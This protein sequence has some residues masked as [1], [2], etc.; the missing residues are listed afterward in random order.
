MAEETILRLL[1]ERGGRGILQ[2]EISEST[3]FSKSTISYFLSKLEDEGIIVRRRVTGSGFRV[4]LKDLESSS[5]LVRVGIVRAAE[6]P[7]I[8]DFKSML[9]E[10]GFGVYLR[11]YDDGVAVMKDLVRG[12]IDAGFSPFITQLIFYATSRRKFRIET[13]GVSGGGSIVL[14]R[15]ARLSEVKKTGSTLASTMD[16]CLTA[17]LRE[18]GLS[19]VEVVY[20]ESPQHMVK[21]LEEGEVQ[22]LSIWEPYVS[23]LE[24]KGHKRITR[25]RDY[26]GLYPCCMLAVNPINEELVDLIVDGFATSLSKRSYEDHAVKLGNLINVEPS[27]V[28]KSILEYTFH[29]EFKV[30]DVSR[31]LKAV[32]LEAMLP[33]IFSG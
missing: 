4:W 33:W 16:A 18:E 25:F 26:I 9:E 11:V 8:F 13:L 7:F 2:S 21:A 19:D 23:I 17:Y 20:F 28:R 1:K 22:M 15:G 30:K 14:R 27:I 32:G 24:S 3:G 31:Y 6:Y 5:K 29:P 10:K 12:K